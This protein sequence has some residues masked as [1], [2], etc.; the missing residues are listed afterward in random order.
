MSGAPPARHSHDQ[1][2]ASI[3]AGTFSVSDGPALRILVDRNRN[4]QIDDE[5]TPMGG[6]VEL[7]GEPTLPVI[8]EWRSTAEFR[9]VTRI[10]LYVG[11]L[12]DHP[13]SPRSRVYATPL[14]GPRNRADLPGADERESYTSSE[15]GIRYVR[16]EDRYWRDPTG[17]LLIEPARIRGV[18]PFEGAVIVNLPLATFEAAPDTPGDRFYVRAFA[19]T[20]QKDRQA[21]TIA[22]RVRLAVFGG[23]PEFIS[24]QFEELVEPARQGACVRHYAFANPVWAISKPVPETGCQPSARA[25]DRDRD[26]LPDGC[27]PCPATVGTRC[28]IAAPRQGRVGSAVTATGPR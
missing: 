9:G 8:V 27:D 10:S 23:F 26:G 3:V 20:A 16:M 24:S 12:K 13:T 6:V 21:C 18:T 2:V 25:L 4:G 14:H 5:D 7:H 11:A 22:E 17:T 28:R 19:E 15:S 1:V